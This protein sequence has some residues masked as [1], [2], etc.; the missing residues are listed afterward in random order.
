MYRT[1]LENSGTL[2]KV[3]SLCSGDGSSGKEVPGHEHESTSKVKHKEWAIIKENTKNPINTDAIWRLVT[4]AFLCWITITLLLFCLLFLL[5]MS[6]M[7]PLLVIFLGI[8]DHL[9]SISRYKRPS[10][11]TI[12]TSSFS[13]LGFKT[14]ASSSYDDAAGRILYIIK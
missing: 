11:F 4:H 5:I 9:Y 10:N 3:A 13:L 1:H 6:S 7:F 2:S 12:V 8:C 14:F